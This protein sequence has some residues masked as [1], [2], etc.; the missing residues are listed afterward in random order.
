MSENITVAAIFHGPEGARLAGIL[1]SAGFTLTTFDPVGTNDGGPHSAAS[2]ADA[3]A[4]ADVVL[5]LN[6]PA[7]SPKVAE[8]AAPL[9]KEGAVYADLNGGTPTTKRQLAELFPEGAFADVAFRAEAGNPASEV[10]LE[11]S[12]TGAHKLMEQ[13]GA[14][15]LAMEYVSK[16][17]GDAAARGIVR[18]L[19][20]KSMA[21]AVIDTL[22][23]AESLG[24]AKWAHQEILQTFE[25]ASAQTTQNSL[26]DTAKNFKRRQMELL[27]VQ[28]TLRGAGYDS[29][30]AAPIDYTYGS[31]M[32]G[33]KIPYSRPSQ[34]RSF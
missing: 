23:A 6:S 25:T 29:T 13:L 7:H 27:D 26:G 12:G 31:L 20:A 15:G 32:H 33:K 18:S 8:Q 1:A 17:P 2:L 24:L 11:V 19:L 4:G 16:V 9:L 3:V 34:V 10:S 5:S 28:E 22:W 30:M 21:A 14:S